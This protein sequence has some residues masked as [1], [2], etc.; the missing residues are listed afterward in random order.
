[1]P[2]RFWDREWAN[3]NLTG[4]QPNFLRSGFETPKG[5]RRTAKLTMMIK[6]PDD[7]HLV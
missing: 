3:E 4:S 1:M 5:M 6:H 2:A 7:Q